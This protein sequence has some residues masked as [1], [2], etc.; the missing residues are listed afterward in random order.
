MTRTVSAKIQLAPPRSAQRLR[1]RRRRHCLLEAGNV[2]WLSLFLLRTRRP[3]KTTANACDRAPLSLPW[4]HSILLFIGHAGI[5]WCTSYSGREVGKVRGTI[6]CSAAGVHFSQSSNAREAAHPN[7]I[8][9]RSCRSAATVR[10]GHQPPQFGR[11][12]GATMPV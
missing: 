2:L 8:G 5:W 12:E 4:Q 3:S 6:T 7:P 11:V 1:K 9:G 10:S